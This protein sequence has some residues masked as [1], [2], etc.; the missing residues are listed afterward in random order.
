MFYRLSVD[1]NVWGTINE[2]R[3]NASRFGQFIFRAFHIFRV[4]HK[5]LND[6]EVPRQYL[7]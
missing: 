5:A 1:S 2:C 7:N 3:A 6:L 4:H